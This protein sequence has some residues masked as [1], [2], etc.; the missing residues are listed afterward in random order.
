MIRRGEVWWADPGEAVRSRP[1]GRRPVLVVQSDPYNDS[2]I[3]TVV[4]VVITSST[5]LASMPGN[6][7]L[8]ARASRLPRDSV[9]DV[10]ACA[11]LDRRD[12]D[13][14]VGVLPE[15]LMTDVDRGLVRVLGL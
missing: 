14:R 1:A 8:P 5:A 10:T 7:F 11:T 6:V 15:R 3:A 12:L 2:R 13:D 4:V 9:V